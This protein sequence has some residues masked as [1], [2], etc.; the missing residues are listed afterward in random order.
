[1]TISRIVSLQEMSV[2]VGRSSKTIWRWY[3]K[4]KVFPTP[5]EINGRAIGWRETDYQAWLN[6]EWHK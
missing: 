2:L 5:I 1:M 6:G 4:E 3:R